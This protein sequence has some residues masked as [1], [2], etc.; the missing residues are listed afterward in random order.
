MGQQVRLIWDLSGTLFRP[1]SIRLTKKEQADYSFLF[2]MW[3]GKKEATFL[4]TIA[5]KVLSLLNEEHK[6]SPEEIVRI[7]TGAPLPDIV[8]SYLAGSLD[9]NQA[10]VKTLPVLDI[11]AP[12]HLSPEDAAQV[13]SM[14]E[15][16]FN[17]SSLARCMQPIGP[18]VDLML[19]SSS[20]PLYILS[21]W[22]HNSFIPFYETYKSTVLAPF[23]RDHI[24]IS[25]D[26]GHVKPQRAI[27]EWFLSH[28]QLNPHECLFIDD[29]AEN[30][31]AAKAFGIEALHLTP[32]TFPLIQKRLLGLV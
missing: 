28:T 7:H 31:A 27:Y 8:C 6:V 26:T 14:L 25:A 12:E 17:A 16:F 18:T 11:W 1:S 23:L 19:K 32:E 2:L 29:Q 5:L 9:G 3:S 20:L 21:N 22:D 24:I 30:I 15:V 4:D 10:L 13:R